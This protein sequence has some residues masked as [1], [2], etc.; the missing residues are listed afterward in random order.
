MALLWT[1]LFSDLSF[2]ICST[3]I[4]YQL[5]GVAVKIK[6]KNLYESDSE[7]MKH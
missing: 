6:Q 3:G 5:L 4:T 7:L 1:G 2:L